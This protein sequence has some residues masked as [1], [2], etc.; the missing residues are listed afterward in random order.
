[1]VCLDVLGGSKK[2]STNPELHS[3]S[4]REEVNHVTH[5]LNSILYMWDYRGE[6]LR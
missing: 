6:D 1:M 3:R 4:Y 2:N 5:V